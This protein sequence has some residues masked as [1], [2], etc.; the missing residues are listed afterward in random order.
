MITDVTK[1]I[2]VDFMCCLDNE[3]YL[4]YAGVGAGAFT[5]L[6]LMQLWPAIN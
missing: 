1:L 6:F 3:K 4:Y 5:V 2:L